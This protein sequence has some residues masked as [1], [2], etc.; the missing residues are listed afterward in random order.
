MEMRHTTEAMDALA[1]SKLLELADLLMQHFK[2]LEMLVE[3]GG[4]GVARRM[5]VT[6]EDQVGLASLDE[7]ERAAQEELL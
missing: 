5:E 3:T 6:P 2:A 7:W 4:W 1:Q